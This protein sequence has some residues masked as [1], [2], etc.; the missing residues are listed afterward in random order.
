M[1]QIPRYPEPWRKDKLKINA[2]VCKP[3]A[4]F[5][6]SKVVTVE[7]DIINEDH[8]DGQKKH[9]EQVDSDDESKHY[10]DM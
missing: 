10:G 5:M 6:D 2:V 4:G 8:K 7:F 3:G 1:A 9:V